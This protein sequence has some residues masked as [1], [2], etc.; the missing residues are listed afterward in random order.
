MAT[1]LEKAEIENYYHFQK[2]C[3]IVLVQWNRE[4]LIKKII[5]GKIVKV[6]IAKEDRSIAICGLKHLSILHAYR[7]P[8][9]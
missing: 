4:K 7:R 6:I 8:L 1:V 3:W 9:R 2:S 5:K